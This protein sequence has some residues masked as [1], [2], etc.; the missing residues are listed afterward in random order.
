MG[1]AQT[2][3]R[4]HSFIHP[5][6]R[7]QAVILCLTITPRDLLGQAGPREAPTGEEA[8]EPVVPV[9]ARPSRLIRPAPLS[10]G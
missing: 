2:G 10:L 5:F 9:S 6:I 3:V 8:S 1:Y 7:Q 4:N